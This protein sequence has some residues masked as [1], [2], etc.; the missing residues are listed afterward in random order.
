VR[1]GPLRWHPG[2]RR[3]AWAT[4]HP[5]EM[6]RPRPHIAAELRSR[7]TASRSLRPIRM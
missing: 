6:L 2:H 5:R 1:R 3:D 7:A 4:P